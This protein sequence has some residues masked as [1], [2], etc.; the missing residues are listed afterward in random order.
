M[1]REELTQE[2]KALR[3][4]LSDM[5]DRSMDRDFANTAFCDALGLDPDAAEM[6]DA[7]WLTL[8]AQYALPDSARE[9]IY[10]AVIA[11]V[12]HSFSSDE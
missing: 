5:F 10:A 2:V 9:I 8:K 7:Q 3:K 1:T 12:K 4:T 11:V 6:T